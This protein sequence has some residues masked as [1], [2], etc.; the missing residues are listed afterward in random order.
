MQAARQLTGGRPAAAPGRLPGE[1][2][3]LDRILAFNQKVYVL[4][5][6]KDEHRK[7]W[8]FAIDLQ[9]DT[10]LGD[11]RGPR[12]RPEPADLGLPELVEKAWWL[13]GYS[14][15]RGWSAAW[16]LPKPVAPALAAGTVFVYRVPRGNEGLT[17]EILER[18]VTLEQ[19][20]IG[21]HRSEGWGWVQICAPFH[22]ET[23]VRK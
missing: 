15:V 17:R 1:M 20:G 7:F 13:A 16:G 12:Y 6:L 19:N 11:A 3:M 5:N 18:C 9:S 21:R 22:F 23:E 10:I 14:Q 8:Y 4:E 2:N